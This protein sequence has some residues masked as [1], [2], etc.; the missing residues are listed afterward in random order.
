MSFAHPTRAKAV[1][2]HVLED[3]L[4]QVV[5]GH[6]EKESNFS[7]PGM[8]TKTLTIFCPKV[9]I[10]PLWDADLKRYAN[11]LHA[12]LFYWLYP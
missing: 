1:Q 3:A 10:S 5:W 11:T 2:L 8:T 6:R 4:N 9:V 7:I 12:M